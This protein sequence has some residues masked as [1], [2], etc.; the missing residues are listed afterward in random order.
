MHKIQ[1]KLL[2]LIL[3][4]EDRCVR[5]GGDWLTD[6]CTLTIFTSVES[7]CGLTGLGTTSWSSPLCT[8]QLDT[9]ITGNESTGV[10]IYGDWNTMDWDFGSSTQFPA[11]RSYKENTAGVQETGEIL[12]GQGNERASGPSTC[13]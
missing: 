6:V 5:A 4:Q 7:T 3:I 10:L 1:I 9:T 2:L 12:C 8:K 11:L 13:P